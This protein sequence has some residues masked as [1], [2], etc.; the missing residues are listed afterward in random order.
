MRLAGLFLCPG[1]AYRLCTIRRR[2]PT[3]RRGTASL[4]LTL[5]RRC[6]RVT[7]RVAPYAGGDV[8]AEECRARA[9]HRG[10]RPD[11]RASSAVTS[12]LC[13]VTMCAAW[14]PPGAGP[15]A[16][17]YSRSVRSTAFFVRLVP[18]QTPV[19]ATPA[20]PGPRVAVRSVRYCTRC[21]AERCASCAGS[22]LGETL[23]IPSVES[24]V[25]Y[26]S[27]LVL[28]SPRSLSL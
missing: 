13:P 6:A 15:D 24:T 18:L 27:L 17:L 14:L 19:A 5:G 21:S 23:G 1:E 11:F 16:G 10:C 2:M 3:Q 12:G 8:A 25:V 9:A 26:V 22:F 4:E 28:F 20:A 7:S